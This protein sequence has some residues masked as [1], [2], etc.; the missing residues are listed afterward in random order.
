MFLTYSWTGTI[1][2][3]NTSIRAMNCHWKTSPHLE[4]NNYF[5]LVIKYILLWVT[6]SSQ[7]LKQITCM[8]NPVIMW[9]GEPLGWFKKVIIT[10][11]QKYFNWNSK[12]DIT[13]IFLRSQSILSSWQ[14]CR[15][16]STDTF[17]HLT[18]TVG[19]QLLH[20]KIIIISSN[21]NILHC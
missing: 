12:W 11:K 19:Y 9:R 3:Y 15:A 2:Y 5:Y 4:I 20:C 8:I 18:V 7:S 1:N 14:L 17:I 6:K 13:I 10:G 16:L 21:T